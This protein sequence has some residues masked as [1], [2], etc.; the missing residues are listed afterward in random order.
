MLQKTMARIAGFLCA[1]V[2]VAAVSGC[3]VNWYELPPDNMEAPA[4]LIQNEMAIFKQRTAVRKSAYFVGKKPTVTYVNPWY[5]T[6]TPVQMEDQFTRQFGQHL[7][8]R[9][10]QMKDL[11]IVG[12]Y[13]GE[14]I[15]QDLINGAGSSFAEDEAAGGNPKTG[16]DLLISYQVTGVSVQESATTVVARATTD[17][18]GVSLS[19]RRAGHIVS[20]SGRAVRLF[21]ATVTANVE[22][23]DQK[24]GRLV[25]SYNVAANSIPT[26]VCTINDI[27]SCMDALAREVMRRYLLQFGPPI[28]VTESRNFGEMVQ[29]NIGAD[30]GVVPGMQFRFLT[31]NK[32]G[33]EWQVG[34]GYIQSGVPEDIGQNYTRIIVRGQGKPENFKVMKNIL[35]R[36]LY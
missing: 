34:T 8:T 1:A 16:A 23:V 22:M 30:Y 20:A 2:S 7:V 28:Y 14:R 21:Y 3:A 24:T 10:G 9:M 25:F 4:E 31:K 18:V 33:Q 26:P 29:I 36:P 11:K 12:L 32:Q 13:A 17:I 5:G 27:S 6:V 19:D 35:A 15:K